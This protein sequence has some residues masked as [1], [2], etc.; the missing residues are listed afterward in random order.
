MDKNNE[1]LNP[2]PPVTPDVPPTPKVYTSQAEQD[3]LVEIINANGSKSQVTKE[4]AASMVA[5]LETLKQQ[6]GGTNA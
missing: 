5:H 3:G 6:L 1:T 4:V 2:T